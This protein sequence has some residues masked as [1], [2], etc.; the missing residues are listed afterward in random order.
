ML[1]HAA[2]AWFAALL[3]GCSAASPTDD[4]ATG[5]SDGAGGGESRP[6]RYIRGDVS[7]R[8]VIELDAVDGMAPRA[9]AQSQLVTRLTDLLDKPGG[10]VAV[11]SDVIPSRGADHA[12]TEAELDA[13]ATSTFDD[14]PTPG[15]IVMH[16]MWLDGHHEADTSSGAVLGVS[17]SNLHIAMFHE[18]IEAACGRQPLLGDPGCAETQYGVWLHEVGHTIGL[19]DNG[20]A[21]T[22]PHQDAAH[23]AHDESASCLMYWQY[24]GS[25][26]ADQI[27]GALLGGGHAPDFDAN[28]LADIAAVRSR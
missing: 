14:D 7:T 27:V 6:E 26:G 12:W 9:A 15:T 3:L 2:L 22:T 8:L 20:I 16:V 21:M 1:R 13:L 4:A 23:P 28:C 24:D 11:A 19:V 5:D 10:V 17:W 18:S 25:A